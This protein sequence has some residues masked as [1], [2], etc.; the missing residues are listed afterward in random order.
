M[1]SRR[2]TRSND[3]SDDSPNAAN[4]LTAEQIGGEEIRDDDGLLVDEYTSEAYDDPDA[5][6]A[7]D[8]PRALEDES[9]LEEIADDDDLNGIVEVDL[10]MGGEATDRVDGGSR[11]AAIDEADMGLGA[12]PHTPEELADAAIGRALRGPAGVT[13][14]DEVHGEG[15]LDPIDE[16]T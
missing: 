3:E 2:T 12:E 1:T 15:L 4:D 14:D 11:R 5:L 7:M 6:D 9:V 8:V 10:L 13:R 16:E